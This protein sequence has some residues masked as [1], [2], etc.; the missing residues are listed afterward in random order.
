MSEYVVLLRAVNVAPRWVKMARLREVL[1]AGGF[2][3]ETYIQSGNLLIGT[4]KRSAAAVRRSLEQVI[5]DEFGFEVPCI[6]RTPAQLRDTLDWVEG[7]ASPLPEATR[8]Y[9]TFFAD[10][11]SHDKV[12]ELD[13]WD[14]DGE[15]LHARAGEVAW[16]LAKSTHEAKLSNARLERGGHVATTRDLKVVRTLVERWA[17]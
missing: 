8:Q 13:A 12:L 10:P 7:L 17:R 2:E 14:V 1:Q 9:V 5:E 4:R 15:R 3:V 11:I 16:W 6:V